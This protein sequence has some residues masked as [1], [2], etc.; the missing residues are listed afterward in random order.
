[1]GNCQPQPPPKE[2]ELK[3]KKKTRAGPPSRETLMICKA[4]KMLGRLQIIRSGLH[5]H[6]NCKVSETA[7]DSAVPPNTHPDMGLPRVCLLKFGHSICLIHVEVYLHGLWVLLQPAG[8]HTH[9]GM[10]SK[11]C[12][13]R[14]QQRKE[15]AGTPFSLV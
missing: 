14:V 6:N 4:H 7:Q 10:G 11:H 12:R 5:F 1:M 15:G 9:T 13:V 2:E 3:E 8:E